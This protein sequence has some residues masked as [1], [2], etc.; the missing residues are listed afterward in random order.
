MNLGTGAK[1]KEVHAIVDQTCAILDDGSMKCWGRNDYNQLGYGDKT[2]RG[3]GTYD[4][5]DNL[6]VVDF[7]ADRKVLMVTG[8]AMMTCA[9]LDDGSVKAWGYSPHGQLG[10]TDSSGNMQHQYNGKPADRPAIDFGGARVKS[11]SCGLRHCCAVLESGT[12]NLM[13]WG[14][15]E[16]GQLGHETWTNE[17]IPIVPK[18]ITNVQKAFAINYISCAIFDDGDTKCWGNLQYGQG[19]T[20]TTTSVTIGNKAGDMDLLQP[21]DFGTDNA[22]NKKTAVHIS[23]GEQFTCAILNDGTVRCWGRATDTVNHYWTGYED[24]IT[25]GAPRDDPVSLLG[26]TQV[27]EACE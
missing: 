26:D 13:C 20:G 14:Q 8:N 25:L 15:G 6:P 27:I 1:P 24:D 7:G 16:Y 10:L 23:G 4:M 11:I 9:L 5:G 2:N 19:G 12:S 21:I 22:L 18:G 3:Q 17:H